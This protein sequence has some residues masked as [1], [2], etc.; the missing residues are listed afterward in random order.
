[1]FRTETIRP[2]ALL[3]AAVRSRLLAPLFALMLLAVATPIFLDQIPPLADYVNHLARMHVIAGIDHDPKLAELYEIRWAVIP[4]LVMD[5]VVPVLNRYVDV[6]VAG[7]L[8]IFATVLLMVSGPMAIHRALHGTITPWP[9]VAFPFVYN[10]IFLV[11]L[12]NYLFGLGV[13]MWGIAAWIALRGRPAALRGAVSAAFVLALFACHLFAVGLYGLALLGLEAWLLT[14]PGALR[15]ARRL[16]ADALAFGLPFLPVLPL[17]LSSPTLGLSHENIWESSGKIDGVYAIIQ[18]Y[19]DAFDMLVG[20]VAVG[21]TVWAAQRRLLWM[22]PAGWAVL[23]VGTAVFLAMPR[24]LFGS[25]MADTRLPVAIFFVM[26]GFLRFDPR[27]RVTR[28][29]FFAVVLGLSLVRTVEVAANWRTLQSVNHDFRESVHFIQP[30]STV[31]VAHAD[32]PSG[33]EVTNA[34]LSHAPCI[35]LIERSALVSTAFSVPGKQILSVRPGYSELVDRND[36]DPPTVSQLLATADGP[37][38]GHERFWD[39]WPARY[40][41]VYVLYTDGEPNPDPDHLAL[42]YEGP[43][44]QLYKVVRP[45]D[46]E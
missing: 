2:A 15:D 6:Y 13:A 14:H 44:F 23:V 25:W 41:Y 1:M 10:G 29:A 46:T 22:H 8:F 20:G 28:Y 7:Q 33:S 37:V 43:R 30:G 24:M 38:P 26:I 27:D 21:L 9:L 45:V 42:L 34:A 31:L 35:A 11:G 12:M 17:M 40:D 32:H 19:A 4:N 36:G 18:T 3:G 39:G 5:M 16:A